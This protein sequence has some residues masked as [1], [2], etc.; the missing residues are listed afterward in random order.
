MENSIR[1]VQAHI[2]AAL[3]QW[4]YIMNDIDAKEKAHLLHYKDEDLF[5]IV[6]MFSHVV[7]NIG[8]HNKTINSAELGEAFG[9]DIREFIKK[10][11]GIDTVELTKRVLKNS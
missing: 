7:S 4:A 5:N 10:Y 8:I 6:L 1:E 11:T 2:S 3:D 9:D